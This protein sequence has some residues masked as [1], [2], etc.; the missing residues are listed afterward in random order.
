[1]A[2]ALGKHSVVLLAGHGAVAVS[3][4]SPEDCLMNLIRLEQL[5]RMNWLAF[6]AVGRDYESYAMGDAPS[7]NT[8]G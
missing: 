5:C 6:T 8:S 4:G 1:M 7:S 2:Q 3:K